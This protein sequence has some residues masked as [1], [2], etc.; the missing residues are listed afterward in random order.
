M[1]KFLILML[2]LVTFTSIGLYTRPSFLMIGKLNWID[3]LT[4]GYFVSSFSK[5]FTQGM[6]DE[7]F[8]WVGQ[9]TLGGLVFGLLMI[10]M[11]EKKA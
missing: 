10:F 7:S 9:F 5:I 1:K 8:F 3:V 4:K 2:S 11:V 6:I